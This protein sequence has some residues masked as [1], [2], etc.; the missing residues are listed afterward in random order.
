MASKS[1]YRFQAASAIFLG[2]R[3]N[4]EDSLV[5][6]FAIGG[7]MGFVVLSDGMGGH[8][9]GDIASKVVVTEV[10]S[11]LKLQSGNQT[12]FSANIS[13]ILRDAA[14]AAN[15]CVREI[16]DGAPSTKGMGATLIVPVFVGDQLFWISIGDSPLFL[17]RD[18]QL[19]QLNE[20][21]SFAPQIDYMVRSGMLTESVGRE[22]PDRNCLTSVLAGQKITKVDCPLAPTQLHDGD[23]VVVASDG[24]QYLSRAEIEDVL[25]NK[26]SFSSE[27]IA[28]SLID[29]IKALDAPDQ[30]NVSLSVIKISN[31]KSKSDWAYNGIDHSK[32]ANLPG[33]PEG[34]VSGGWIASLRSR[35]ARLYLS[36]AGP[37]Q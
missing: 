22:H 3:D 30:D 15:S 6:D 37:T 33:H 7:D 36:A 11:E 9:A 16:A 19:S 21:H 1:E 27:L 32:T 17:F 23:I 31:R 34:R 10:F 18:G 14:E 13:T 4:Q 5:T 28:E 26:K 20:D 29:E 12:N 24:L 2:K 25:V 8:N 35:L